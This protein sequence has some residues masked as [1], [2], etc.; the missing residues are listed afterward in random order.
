MKKTINVLWTGGLDSTCR[1]VELSQYDIIVQPYYMLDKGRKS[2]K[3][4]LRAIKNIT[5]IIRNNPNTKCDLKDPIITDI[6]SI[7]EDSVITNAWIII[8]AKYSLGIQYDWLA[9]F[10]KQQKIQLEI[11]LEKSS[12]S[13]AF[14]VIDNECSLQECDMEGIIDYRIDTEFSKNEAKLLFE[15]LLMPKTLWNMTKIEEV[16]EIKELGL[17]EVV[18]K[19]WFCHNPIFGLPCGNCNPCKDALKEEMAYRI[20]KIGLFMGTIRKNILDG[21]RILKKH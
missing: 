12:R 20:P 4:E 5:K 13:K 3:Q 18:S 6:N 17:G 7:K 15:N 10:A 16:Q 2:I 19:T 1:V 14:N 11:G 8:H 21:L 9:R